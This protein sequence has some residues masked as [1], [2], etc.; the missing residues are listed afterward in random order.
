MAVHVGIATREGPVKESVGLVLLC[1]VVL[2]AA[3]RVGAEG[4]PYA[5]DPYEDAAP[6]PVDDADP[7]ADVR[8]TPGHDAAGA[9]EPYAVDP[10]EADPYDDDGD[11]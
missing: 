9:G 1:A 7:R 10:Y 2:I 11:D 8:A 3:A 6:P 5:R 4:D